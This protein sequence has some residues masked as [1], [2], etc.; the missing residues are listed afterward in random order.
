MFHPPKQYFDRVV[1]KKVFAKL[2]IIYWQI[3]YRQLLQIEGMP[4]IK[5]ANEK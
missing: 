5:L 3:Q 1:Q 4:I 2:F